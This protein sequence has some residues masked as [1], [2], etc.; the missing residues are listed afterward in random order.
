MLLPLTVFPDIKKPGKCHHFTAFFPK[1]I[2]CLLFFSRFPFIKTRGRYQASLIFKR[3]AVARPVT[4]VLSSCIYRPVSYPGIFSPEGDQSPAYQSYFFWA[5]HD[6]DR[7]RPPRSYVV[8]RLQVKIPVGYLKPVVKIFSRYKSLPPP[9]A[10]LSG[11]FSPVPSI[12]AGVITYCPQRSFISSMALAS[13]S[14]LSASPNKDICADP[15]FTTS[16]Q[17][18]A[19]VCTGF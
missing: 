2:R 15:A 7:H 9:K 11:T 13:R 3:P 4:H 6:N 14:F 18:T 1:I 8:T 5:V 10:T 17:D 16:K 19:R 12:R